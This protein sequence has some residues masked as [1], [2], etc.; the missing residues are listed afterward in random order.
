VAWWF[1]PVD[2]WL[3]ERDTRPIGVS[4]I[5]RTTL[6]GHR[7][8]GCDTRS[9]LVKSRS[10]VIVAFAELTTRVKAIGAEQ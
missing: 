2:E 1:D 10:G 4:K 9:R 6:A 3:T 8:P 7:S 5:S